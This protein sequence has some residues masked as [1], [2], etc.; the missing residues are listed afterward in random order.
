M[1]ILSQLIE[2]KITLAQAIG[3][4]ETWLGQTET[5]IEKSIAGDPAVQAAVSTVITDGK[6]ALN[7]GADWA[8]T[9]IAG[10]LSDFAGELA[11]L[12]S[13]YVPTLIGTAG[14]PFA[15]AAVTAIQALGQVGVAA[16]QHEVATIVTGSAETAAPPATA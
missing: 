12:V 15:A 11:G 6:A 3:E 2:G 1:S 9:A 16:I 10:G 5:T 13:K 7:V 8:G 14:G 4:A